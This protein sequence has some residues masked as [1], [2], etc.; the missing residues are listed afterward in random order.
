MTDNLNAVRARLGAI[1]IEAHNPGCLDDTRERVVALLRDLRYL[2]IIKG[3]SL[4]SA[5][6]Q[7]FSEHVAEKRASMIDDP[8]GPIFVTYS[9]MTGEE[10]FRGSDAAKVRSRTVA[11]AEDHKAKARMC[12]IPSSRSL[13]YVQ[14]EFNGEA[15]TEGVKLSDA[16]AFC[17]KGSGF[18][19]YYFFPATVN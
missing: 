19:N 14:L 18:V 6:N 15:P 11:D 8:I 12:G 17:S 3:F 7:A 4:E 13:F 16:F 1:A 2:G 10:L 5:A 9:Q